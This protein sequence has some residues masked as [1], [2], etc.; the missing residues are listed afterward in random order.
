MTT[1]EK[2]EQL[3]GELN[4]TDLKV[5]IFGQ[6]F[7]V[8]PWLKGRLFYKIITGNET[9]QKRDFKLY[10]KQITSIF[11]GIFNLFRRYDIWAFSTS[12]E[13]RRIEGKQYDKL[14]DYIGNNSG[15]KTLLI[16]MRIFSYYPYRTIASRYA[17]SR[18]FFFLFEEVYGRLFLRH[19]NV[20]NPELLHAIN[21]K[22]SEGIDH[23]TLL[24]KYLAQYRL[25]KFWLKILPKPKLVMLSVGYTNFGYIKAFKENGIKVAEVQHGVI[26]KNHHAYCYNKEFNSD[27]F[28]DY[29]LTIGRKEK[30]V[31][32]ATN[33]F[34]VGRVI[35]VGSFIIDY[36]ASSRTVS[37]KNKKPLVLFTLQ[38]GQM[39]E[40]FIEFILGFDVAEYDQFDILIQPRRNSKEY[41]LKRFPKLET[42]E[43]SSQDFYSTVIKADLH[44]TVYS[45]TAIE[46]LS[47]G[48]P[49]I[50]V[51][52]DDQSV[53]QLDEVLGGNQFTKV[54][55]NHAAFLDAL[56]LLEHSDP[57]AVKRSNEENIMVNYKENI[58][59]FLKDTI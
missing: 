30:A 25:M 39:G 42:V 15:C 23:R 46:S 9:L 26:T 36:Y 40:K 18:S 14:F 19:I 45:T 35:P 54:V 51:N 1:R 53:E 55:E 29:L 44:C 34:P 2:V 8:Y 12:I 57:E 6:E 4:V 27:Q 47:L 24:R 21:A 37:R 7:Q 41:Y 13:R 17:I 58:L 20:N 3:E 5:K 43:F 16:E 38:D 50:L 33:K 11:Y 32:D 56:M 48:V 10:W 22:V 28:P 49:N 52:I 59:K 31:F